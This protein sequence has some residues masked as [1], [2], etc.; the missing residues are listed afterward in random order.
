MKTLATK[1]NLKSP[2][3]LN[4]LSQAQIIKKLNLTKGQVDYFRYLV[5]EYDLQIGINYLYACLYPSKGYAQTNRKKKPAR[6]P[7]PGYSKDR[8]SNLL[9]PNC[10]IF[11]R[12]SGKLVSVKGVIKQRYQCFHCFRLYTEVVNEPA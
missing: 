11:T 7:K 9:C 12:K 5:W 10:Q 6:G 8:S 2:E 3:D 4:R 1:L